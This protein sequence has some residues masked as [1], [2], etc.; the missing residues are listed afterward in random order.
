MM[1]SLTAL[2]RLRSLKRGRAAWQHVANLRPPQEA[3]F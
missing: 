2:S 1:K 3:V